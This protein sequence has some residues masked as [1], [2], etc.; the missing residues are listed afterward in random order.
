MYLIFFLVI[1]LVSGRE[2]CQK[3]AIEGKNYRVQNWNDAKAECER[4]GMSLAKIDDMFEDTFLRKYLEQEN[5][6]SLFSL[7]FYFNNEYNIQY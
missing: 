5:R 2:Y 7:Q 3:Y 6:E 4:M 1:D